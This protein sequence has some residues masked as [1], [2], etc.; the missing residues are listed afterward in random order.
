MAGIQGGWLQTK[1]QFD[2]RYR[3]QTAAALARKR[4][5]FYNTDYYYLSKQ[6][7]DTESRLR[8]DTWLNNDL[9]DAVMQAT[10]EAP[11]S[12]GEM[13]AQRIE[14]MDEIERYTM[15]MTPPDFTL[16]DDEKANIRKGLGQYRGTRQDYIKQARDARQK[17][18]G[19]RDQ[20]RGQTDAEKLAKLQ[21]QYA[22]AG[23]VFQNMMQ[24]V[25]LLRPD[26]DQLQRFGLEN[27]TSLASRGGWMG[28]SS[29]T[30][31]YFDRLDKQIDLLR[32]ID[33]NTRKEEQSIWQ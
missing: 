19:L 33:E 9:L 22:E 13:Q 29:N 14:M 1:E 10:G 15:L 32:S 28:E 26:G 21:K 4:N 27:L 16:S 3:Q 2:K 25:E 12:Y 7:A 24:L 20:M 8:R 30:T 5:S 17:M 6:K 18:L 23:S 11:I 31:Q